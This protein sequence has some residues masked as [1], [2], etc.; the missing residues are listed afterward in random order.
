MRMERALPFRPDGSHL[1]RVY[2]NQLSTLSYSL[3]ALKDMPGRKILIMMTANPTLRKPETI[4]LSNVITPID[5]HALYNERFSR[6]AEDALRAG[7]VVNFLNINGLTAQHELLT[8]IDLEILLMNFRSMPVSRSEYSYELREALDF[9]ARREEVEKRELT[10]NEKK[11]IVELIV[12]EVIERARDASPLNALNPLPVKTGGVIIENSNFFLDGI[13]RETESLMKGY[14]LISYEPPPDTFNPG[15]R[16]IFNQIKVN[17]RRGNVRVHTRDGFYNRLESEMTAAVASVHPL[18]EVI[19]SPFLHADLTVNM[20]AG[21]IRDAKSGYFVRSWIHIDPT[22]LNIVETE[23]GGARIDIEAFCVTS[24][25]DGFVQDSRRVYFTLTNIIGVENI[26][27]LRKQGIRFAMLLPVSKPGYYYVRIAV[28]DKESGKVGSAYQFVEIPDHTKRGLAL[29]SI[30]M[31]SGDEDLKWMHSDVRSEAGGVLRPGF[32]GEETPSPA[33][34]TYTSGDSLQILAMLYNADEKAIAGSEIETQYILYR[35]GVEF[36]RSEPMHV[37]AAVAENLDGIPLWHRFT[38][39][40]D[41]PPG[42]Y[43]FQLQ[44]RDRRS[45]GRRE[46]RVSQVANFTVVDNPLPEPSAALRLYPEPAADVD[47]E[48]ADNPSPEQLPAEQPESIGD[49]VVP[50]RISDVPVKTRDADTSL[51]EI[52]HAVQKNVDF[53]KEHIIDLVSEEKITIE[54]YNNRGRVGRTTSIISEYRIFP[55]RTSSIPDCRV[56]YEIIESLL[57]VG[58]LREEREL[59]SAKEN[60]REQRLDRFRFTEHFWARGS[61]YVELMILFDKQNEGCFDYELKGVGSVDGRNVYVI[62]IKQREADVGSVHAEKDM[63]ISW[64]VRY[65]GSALIDAETMDIVQLN[66]DRVTIGHGVQ[67]T[68]N[69]PMYDMFPNVTTIRYF[70]FIQYEY[71]KVSINDRFLTLPVTKT[72][73]LFRETGQPDISYKYRYGNHRAFT[74][75][76]KISFE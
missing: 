70:L 50:I 34:R 10:L 55:E 22:D 47:V 24:D 53:L 1:Y 76:T 61:S 29:S 21:Y 20:S 72:V 69:A 73:S 9:I 62:G 45:S 37:S 68:E 18:Q 6:L 51:S 64:D 58:I 12:P 75:D 16:E 33:L 28:E 25:I 48:D 71:E 43:V 2:D 27:R 8:L 40:E 39:S 52:L 17:V 11:E 23:D 13:G 74:V 67:R 19:F 60:N 38:I 32:Y 46:D 59:L 49:P 63:N 57:P 54:E 65:E 56:V 30:F 66:R 14:Y 31:F 44:A 5:F 42:D 7:V 26:A 15:D 36:L 41:L 4:V 3:R 35:D